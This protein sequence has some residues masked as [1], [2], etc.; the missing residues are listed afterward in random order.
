MKVYQI[1]FALMLLDNYMIKKIVERKKF[2][3]EI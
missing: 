3:P 1:I 2:M